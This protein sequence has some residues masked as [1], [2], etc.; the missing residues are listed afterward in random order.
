M[1]LDRYF[2]DRVYLDA[3]T[4]G[5][6]YDR[7]HSTL[8]CKTLELPWRANQISSDPLKA[9][10]IPEGIYL[11]ELQQPT[12]TRPYLHYRIVHVPGRHWHPD[13]KRSSVLV[14]PANYA[15]QLLGC[16][17]P[18]SRHADLNKDK[19]IDIEDSKVKLAWLTKYLPSYFELQIGRKPA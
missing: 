15:D 10:C 16:I 14:H 13:T 5:S 19:I 18:G 11:L 6:W 17:A 4:P 8:L 9:S 2:L 3:S 7:N 1:I 12:T